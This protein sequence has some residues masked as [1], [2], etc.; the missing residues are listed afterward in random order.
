MFSKAC[1]HTLSRVLHFTVSIPRSLVH[2]ISSSIPR[3][4][5]PVISSSIHH[6]IL[7]VSI[8]NT[9]PHHY[10]PLSLPHLPTSFTA[11]A[12]LLPC[13]I[14]YS[15]LIC[16]Y[17]SLT[18]RPPSLHLPLSYHVLSL[19]PSL[20]AF[21]S[22]SLVDLLHCIRLSLTM[23]N[24]LLPPYLP[25]SLTHLP[26]SFTASASLLQC[27]ISYS[28]LICLFLSLTCR[29]PS[30][31]PPFS[32]HVLSLLSPYLPLSLPHLPT[33]F[34]ASASLLPFNLIIY[35]DL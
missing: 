19:T 11:S 32:Y 16:L 9:L 28:L 2:A 26:T 18:C 5:V 35:I 7:H 22:H 25:L 14:S 30:L 15:L 12:S 4:L 31:H 34:T 6:S 27:I 23:Y 24:L 20:S 21:I 10:L 3:S 33:S 1:L 8:N 13:I 29:P 17:L